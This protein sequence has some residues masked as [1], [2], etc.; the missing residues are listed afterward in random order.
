MYGTPGSNNYTSTHANN[1]SSTIKGVL[2]DWYIKNIKDKGYSKYVST[3]VGF[4][5]DRR[6]A[7]AN[8]TFWTSDTKKGYGTSVT[9]YGP[10]P[11]FFAATGTANWLLSPTPTLRCSQIDS[12]MFTPVSSNKGNKK[13]ND[14]IGLITVDEMVFGGGKGYEYT[15]NRIHDYYL[16][17]GQAYWT[18]SPYKYSG[19]NSMY[20]FDVSSNGEIGYSR[21]SEMIGVRPVINLASD[22][23]ITG[24]GTSSDPYV[25]V[26]A[27]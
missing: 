25:V 12:D 3:E 23:K 2:D 16:Y 8:E 27:E 7:G 19:D 5:N 9:V 11:R 21:V 4:C 20:M 6:V 10:Y 13:L 15:N 18:I 14:P 26:G 1:N 17:T 24:S 22:V